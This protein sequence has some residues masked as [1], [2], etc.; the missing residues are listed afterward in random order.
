VSVGVFFFLLWSAAT[1]N[2]RA[3]LKPKSSVLFFVTIHQQHNK[4]NAAKGTRRSS[5]V[6]GRQREKSET[7]VRMGKK[8]LLYLLQGWETFGAWGETL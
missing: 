6:V 5:T 4:S 8:V 2:T 1:H 3:E 7:L